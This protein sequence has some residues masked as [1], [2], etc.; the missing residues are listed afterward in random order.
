[1][2]CGVVIGLLLIVP[3]PVRAAVMTGGET[4]Y[5]TVKGDSLLLI[6]AK[7]G[8]DMEIIAGRNGLDPAG[9]LQ[10]DQELRL[11]TRTITP[12]AVENGIV[13]CIPGMMLYYF[14]AGRLDMGFPVGIGMPEWRGLTRWRTPA[15][16][17]IITGKE[18]YPLW[19]VPESLQW[20]MQVQEKPVVTRVPPGPDNPL[21]RLVL[22]TS[23]RGIAIHETLWPTTVYRFRSHGCI[24]VL[25]NAMERLYGEMEVGTPGELVY[26]PVKVAVTEEGR[27]FLEADPD[28]YG[29]IGK[30]LDGGH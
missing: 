22:Y 18:R 26:E 9:P 15:G 11:D 16:A 14:K 17:F 19:Y 24:R 7:L 5:R 20:Q 23:I 25:S 13:V 27:V 4:V 12:R 29:K 8:V 21:G 2:K 10:P 28:V 30:P 1:M 6:N 3:F